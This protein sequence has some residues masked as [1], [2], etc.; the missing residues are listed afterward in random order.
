MTTW[1]RRLVCVACLTLTIFTPQRSKTTREL[2]R[3][4]GTLL[5]EWWRDV[6]VAGAR[7]PV[8]VGLVQ[9]RGDSESTGWTVSVP[10]GGPPPTTFLL[11]LRTYTPQVVTRT[12]T[13]Q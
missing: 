6:R 9:C 1:T 3:V 10:V 5:R 8:C 4:G 11:C 12:M 2:R 13:K 7:T